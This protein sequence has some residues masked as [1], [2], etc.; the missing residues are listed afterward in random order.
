M[1]RINYILD[2]LG[3]ARYISC[4]NLK[5]GYWQIPLEESSSQFM[6]FTV[7]GKG[8]L[9]WR[10][11]PFGL[12]SASATFPTL[13]VT[14]R[15]RLPGRHKTDRTHARRTQRKPKRSNPEV[16]SGKMPIS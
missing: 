6:A 13:N 15:I 10:V 4:L 12:H 3:E 16:E 8:L 5:D 1:P 7:P 9:Q 2:Q 11:K 14:S